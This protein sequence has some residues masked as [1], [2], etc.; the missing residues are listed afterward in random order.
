[1]DVSFL[2]PFSFFRQVYLGMVLGLCARFVSTK[3]A[4]QYVQPKEI[5]SGLSS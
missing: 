4:A 3:K 2:F 1:M 5:T